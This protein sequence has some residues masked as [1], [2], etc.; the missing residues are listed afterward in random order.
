MR[1]LRASLAAFLL[2]V[3]L[4]PAVFAVT[5]SMTTPYPSV[6]ADPGTTVKFPVTVQT[7]SSTRVD[8]S[9][10]Q[11][12]QGWQTRLSGG[13]ST[14]SAVTT[15]PF[16]APANAQATPEPVN[17]NYATFTVEIPVPADATAGDNQIVVQ[18]KATDGTTQTI[19]LDVSV[20][21]AQTG[22]VTMSTSFPSL[23][24][25]ATTTFRFSVQLNNNTNQQITFGLQTD[26]P[27]G[28]TV[29][30]APS[31]QTSA[32]SAVVDA[33]S[34][35]D[36]SVVANAPDDATAGTYNITLTAVG[37]PTPIQQ[38]LTVDL[39]GTKSISLA[40]SD[41]RLNVNVQSGSSSQ[42]NFVI[43]NSGTQDL[44]GVAMTSTPPIDWTVTFNPESVDIPAGQ[45]VTVQ[46]TVTPSNNALAGDYQMTFNARN[47]DSSASDSV[48]IRATVETSPIGYIIGIAILVVVGVGL[49]FVFQR[50]GRR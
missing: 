45:D 40:T 22:D 36:I 31:T 48:S 29:T 20:Q 18:G 43:T 15:I 1:V 13:G 8:L 49:F 50:Y 33:G 39:T 30:A 12:P 35:Q 3:G 42:I 24:G 9:V 27:A 23:S 14:I 2:L 19:N 47:P 17:G 16:I 32:S 28:W 38:A 11:Q 6:V 21:T 25:P 10:T 7:D 4:A 34:S 37:G 26:E 46:A 44:T 41:Q 5:M